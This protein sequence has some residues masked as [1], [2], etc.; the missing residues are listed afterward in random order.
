M[1]F[2]RRVDF[3]RLRA[4]RLARA[5]AALDKSTC[6]ALL[7]FDVNNIRY[8]T[9]TKIG[10]WERDKLCRF[11]LLMRGKEPI[12]WDFGS[13]AVHH[14]LYCDWLVAD[15]RARRHARHARHRPAGGRADAE[16]RRG[17]HVASETKPAWERCRSA[18]TSPRRRCSS[19]CRRPA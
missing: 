8:V 5:R 17:D 19:S 9:A 14:R 6:G 2:E 1:D 3:D 12:V 10:E 13:A 4:Y 7:L 11:A 15:Q 16:P 18:S